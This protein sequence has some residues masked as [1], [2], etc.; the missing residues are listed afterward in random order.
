MCFVEV[1]METARNEDQ[2]AYVSMLQ[3]DLPQIVMGV[4]RRDDN[5]GNINAPLARRVC[6]HLWL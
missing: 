3:R 5:G 4:A 6:C 1:F 2:Q